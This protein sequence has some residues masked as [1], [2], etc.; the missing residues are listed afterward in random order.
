[1]QREKYERRIVSDAVWQAFVGRYYP[2]HQ[3]PNGDIHVAIPV[4]GGQPCLALAVP[5]DARKKSTAEISEVGSKKSPTTIDDES[6]LA[7]PGHGQISAPAHPDPEQPTPEALRAAEAFL[8]SI[9]VKPCHPFGNLHPESRQPRRDLAAGAR[10]RPRI[11]RR[12]LPERD[13]RIAEDKA[14]RPTQV[15]IHGCRAYA[16]SAR[17]GPAQNQAPADACVVRSAP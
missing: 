6:S 12:D 7:N 1:M 15:A 4:F 9:A 16:R 2:P 11:T 10:A 17:H 14:R 13:P 5:F 3:R 8:K